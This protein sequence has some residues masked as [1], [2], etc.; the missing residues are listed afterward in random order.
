MPN[1]QTVTFDVNGE[2]TLVRLL[3]QTLLDRA[4]VARAAE[5]WLADIARS[6]CHHLVVDC[7]G[8]E[9]LSSEVLSVLLV[10][11]R[12]LK[13][14]RAKMALCGVSPAIRAT[15]T[16]TRIDRMFDIQDELPH[17]SLA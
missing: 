1:N 3:N 9:R 11:D 14:S 16:A 17:R 5:G 6:K 15:F 7:S 2:A 8:L 4:H 13:R 12:R 10:L